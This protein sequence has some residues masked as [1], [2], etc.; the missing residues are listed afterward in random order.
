MSQFSELIRRNGINVGMAI[1]VLANFL[2]QVDRTAVFTANLPYT[3]NSLL[4]F[5]VNQ[6]LLHMYDDS[7]DV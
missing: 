3:C 5:Q 2:F 7:Y 1:S 6:Y 4:F